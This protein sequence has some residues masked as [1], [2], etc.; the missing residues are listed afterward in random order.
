MKLLKLN[1]ALFCSLCF[2]FSSCLDLEPKAS[3]ADSNIWQTP[4]H[5]K[6][7]ANQFYGWLRDFNAVT[8]DAPHSDYRS[9]LISGNTRNIYS[10]GTNPIP[11]TD[12]NFTDAYSR[13]R[14][15]NVLLQKAQ[16]YSNQKDIEVSVGEAKFFRAY[17][18]FDL[19]QL[20]GDVLIVK[21]PL[22]TTSPE[23]KMERNPRGEVVDFIIQDLKEAIEI[24]PAYKSL[25]AGGGRVSQEA[26]QAFLSRVAL[27]EGT[28][29]KFRVK[30][31]QRAK[32]L[33]KIAQTAAYDVM[34]GGQFSLFKPAELGIEAYKYL[35]VL[36]NAKCNPSS[37]TKQ[38]NNEYI[39]RREYDSELRALGSNPAG[40]FFG[41]SSFVLRKFANMFLT[42][43]GLPI[44]PTDDELYKTMASE[45]ANRDNRMQ[46]LLL[47]A[48]RPYWTSAKGRSS[49]KEDETDLALAFYKSFIPNMNSCYFSQKW[50]AERQINGNP[51]FDFPVIRYAE[52]L[53]NYAEAVFEQYESDGNPTSPEITKALDISLNLVRQRVNPTMPKLSVDFAGQHSLSMREEIRRERTIELFHEGFRIDD[54][55]RWN[56]AKEEMKMDLLGVKYDGTEF[57]TIW[58]DMK[59]K[60]NAEG[61][62][63]L[64]T[65]RK[66]EEKNYLY[67]LPVDQLQL[68]PNLKQNPGWGE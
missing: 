63:I 29:Q 10:N 57:E 26:A 20:Y 65:G 52:V 45:Y 4:D 25:T 64:E 68:N 2:M 8:S 32:D 22:E 66:W 1:I 51:G 62:I 13:I 47:I 21:Q 27:Y 50:N 31:V 35:F 38:N 61:C 23:L 24:L 53:L 55:K 48:G 42:Q 30:D 14:Q 34:K 40:A 46:N 6:L 15:V 28:W 58:K 41:K 56:T 17:L 33:L 54:L 11:S 36:E 44:D 12:N 67:P 7:F 18:Y 3:L 60:T 16:S 43:K 5:Y 37:Y 49:W 39:L 19:V 9:D 59:W